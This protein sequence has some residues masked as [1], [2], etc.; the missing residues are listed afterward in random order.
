MHL[1]ALNWCFL[2]DFLNDFLLKLACFSAKVSLHFWANIT[3]L[4]F[5]SNHELKSQGSLWKTTFLSIRAKR[6]KLAYKELG[7]FPWVCS[8]PTIAPLEC[9]HSW[10]SEASELLQL[11]DV[12]YPKK[13]ALHLDAASWKLGW[14]T[15]HPDFVQVYLVY[16]VQ[17]LVYPPR[18]RGT[19]V[20]QKSS[21]SQGSVDLIHI[22]SPRGWADTSF[23]KVLMPVCFKI[24]RL[25]RETSSARWHSVTNHLYHLIS[26]CYTAMVVSSS[27]FHVPEIENTTVF[28]PTRF[29]YSVS[30]HGQLR[31]TLS[32][33]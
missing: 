5:T 23:W 17:Y 16:P 22:F 31:H 11:H 12:E 13:R 15:C 32:C 33:L 28:H 8:L 3:Y 30:W 1:K 21:I 27:P 24:S 10:H 26:P 20:P 19:D 9:L 18:C 6:Q 4:K 7:Q 14:Q 25:K 2:V 29:M